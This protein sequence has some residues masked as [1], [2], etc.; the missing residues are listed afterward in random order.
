VTATVVANRATLTSA[1]RE[2]LL[3][4]ARRSP[5]MLLED[6]AHDLG[7]LVWWMDAN[8]RDDLFWRLSQAMEEL[9]SLRTGWPLG[10]AME[11]EYGGS[12]EGARQL[13]IAQ[14]EHETHDAIAAFV[15]AADKAAAA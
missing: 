5:D 6:V 11:E 2:K 8:N 13:A 14:F 1:T 10:A 7:R 15:R 9:E 12:G 3:D 4:L